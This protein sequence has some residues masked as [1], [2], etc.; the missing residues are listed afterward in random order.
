[1][2]APAFRSLYNAPT[3]HII[4]GHRLYASTK[5]NSRLMMDFFKHSFAVR[6]RSEFSVEQQFKES[7]M[8]RA[9]HLCHPWLYYSTY[10]TDFYRC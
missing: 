3:Q 5:A 6:F 9:K 8:E 4:Y 1:M 2:V 7:T 10:N